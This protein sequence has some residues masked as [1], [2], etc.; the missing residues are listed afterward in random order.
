MFS[1]DISGIIPKEVGTTEATVRAIGQLMGVTGDNRVLSFCVQFPRDLFRICCQIRGAL[2]FYEIL[3]SKGEQPFPFLTIPLQENQH[4]QQMEWTE[5]R[6]FIG[7]SSEYISFDLNT[8]KCFQL[9]SLDNTAAQ[10]VC[11][12]E[13]LLL[14]SGNILF[15]FFLFVKM[16]QQENLFRKL[17]IFY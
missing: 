3:G 4:G 1:L 7:T 9:F 16:N 11:T 6:C 12:H 14:I 10:I 8:Q 2:M 5:K 15:F 13:D 17:R